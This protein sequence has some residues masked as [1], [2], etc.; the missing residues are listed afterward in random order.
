MVEKT[1]DS[2]RYSTP[3]FCA[4]CIL[5]TVA[6]KSS[7]DGG[8]HQ[9]KDAK[10][11]TINKRNYLNSSMTLLV[12]VFEEEKVTENKSDQTTKTES[13]ICLIWIISTIFLSFRFVLPLLLPLLMEKGQRKKDVCLVWKE[14]EKVGAWKSMRTVSP[15]IESQMDFIFPPN[16]F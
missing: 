13:C 6:L 2:L 14:G 8:K 9:K 3:F 1:T 4:L 16:G 7:I 12:F 10:F 11:G 5:G 15:E